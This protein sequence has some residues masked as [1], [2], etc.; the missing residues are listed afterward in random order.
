MIS[1]L[2]MD[3]DGSL[4]DGKIYMGPDGELAKA[5]SIKDGYA[6]NYILKPANIKPVIITA[7]SSSIVQNRCNELGIQDVFQGVL[8]KFTVLAKICDGLFEKCAYFGD[9]L[10]DLKCMI[11][12]KAAGGIVGC[13]ADAV[14]EIKAISDYVCVNKAG[15]GALREFAEWIVKPIIDELELKKRIN[16]AID[17]IKGLNIDNIPINEKIV[18]DDGFYYSIQSYTTKFEDECNFESHRKYVDVQFMVSGQERMDISDISRLT[19]KENYDLEKD[20]MFWNIPKH[21][22][23]VTLNTGDLIVLYPENAHRGSIAEID[24]SKVVKIVGKVCIGE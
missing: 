9:D 11:P 3:V 14:Q 17:Y 2:I 8:D 15:E 22:A 6:M 19:V 12:I 20:V 23:C 5:F 24:R 4:T 1:Y 10:I 7:R 21:M 16:S 18:V 13:P